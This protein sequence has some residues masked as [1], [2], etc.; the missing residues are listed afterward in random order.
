MMSDPWRPQFIAHR[1]GAACE[2][3]NTRSAFR[4]AVQC[5]VD[6]VE[7]DL[8]LSA[9]GE[10][11]LFHDD[12]MEL[13]GHPSEKLWD[14]TAEKLRNGRYRSAAKSEPL[15]SYASFLSD[16]S[17]H[18]DVNLYIEFK[19]PLNV[20][21][22]YRENMIKALLKSDPAQIKNKCYWMSFDKELLS[23]W[24]RECPESQ[25]IPLLDDNDKI[26]EINGL[27]DP[28]AIGHG[29]TSWNEDLDRALS[30]R[31]VPSLCFTLLSDVSIQR[32]I[33]HRIEHWMCDDPS[34]AMA[35]WKRW[36]ESAE[37]RS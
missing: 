15:L 7:C 4:R 19:V 24:A 5:G 36:T 17:D 10:L 29:I 21:P 28:A 20:P 34:G 30:K 3:E 12:T 14:W 31:G 1:G 22:E 33:D 23:L 2:M 37:P 25:I 6:G 32:A 26:D 27:C 13:L 18:P 8:Q 35:Y 9:D 16:L 11:F